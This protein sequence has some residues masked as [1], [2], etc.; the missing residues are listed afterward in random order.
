MCWGH[1]DGL[2]RFRVEPPVS[3]TK[4]DS[5]D[6]TDFA[7]DDRKFEFAIEWGCLDVA[8]SRDIKKLGKSCR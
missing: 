8:P 3:M 6:R 5:A 2:Q 4:T 1:L 7:V